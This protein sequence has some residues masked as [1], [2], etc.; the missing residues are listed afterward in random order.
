MS[1]NPEECR[2]RSWAEWAERKR[3]NKPDLLGKIEKNCYFCAH[4]TWINVGKTNR[5]RG[6]DELFCHRVING[7]KRVTVDITGRVPEDCVHFELRS[8]YAE[9]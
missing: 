4:C 3:T 1:V 8:K 6:V 7:G 9:K 2:P 5:F